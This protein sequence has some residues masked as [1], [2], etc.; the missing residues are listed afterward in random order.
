[1]A[2]IVPPLAADNQK[3]FPELCRIRALRF[4]AR[5]LGFDECSALHEATDWLQLWAVRSGLVHDIGQDAVQAI[6][7]D[8][9]RPHRKDLARRQA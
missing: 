5:E 1:M 4:A 8:A 9:F 6:I 2:D 3:L 7:S